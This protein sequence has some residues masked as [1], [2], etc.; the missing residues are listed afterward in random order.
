MLM[1]ITGIFS[2][3]THKTGRDEEFL[4]SQKLKFPPQEVGSAVFFLWAV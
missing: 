4:P 3:D 1:N 2:L